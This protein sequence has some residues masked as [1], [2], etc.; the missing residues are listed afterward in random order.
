MNIELTPDETKLIN[1]AKEKVVHYNQIRHQNDGLDTLYSFV[2]SD[3]GNIY[4]GAAF[5]SQLAHA[6]ICAERQAIANLILNESYQGELK[7]VLI[8]DPAPEVQERS[9]P[10]CGTCRHIIW[11]TGSSDTSVILMQYIQGKGGWTFPKLEKHFI[12]DLYPHPY[13]PA[14]G[15]WDNF[16]PKINTPKI[17]LIK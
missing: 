3:E 17:N 1:H 13:E 16:K 11:T 14:E 10:P 6:S 9:T 7:S 12:K 2:L 15:L 8:A 4:D 5:E